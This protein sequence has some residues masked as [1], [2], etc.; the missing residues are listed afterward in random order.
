MSFT[1]EYLEEKKKK[2][3]TTAAKTGH[4]FTDNY[5]SE[6]E[7]SQ[8]LQ[9]DIAPVRTAP[10]KTTTKKDEDEERTWFKSGAFD[11]GYQFGD[12]TKTILGTVGD[13]GIGIAKGIGY[14]GEGVGDLINYADASISEKLGNQQRADYIRKRT[15]ESVTDI[16]LGGLE[17]KVDRFSVLGDK[18]DS[19]TQGI[20]QVGA[21]IATGGIAGAAGLGA[22]GTTGVT[23]GLMGASSAGSGMSEAYMSGATDEEAATYGLIKGVVDAGSEMIFGGLGKTVKA[24]GISKGLSS[25]DDVFAQKL[26]NRITNNVAKNFVEYGV[27]ASAEGVEEVLAG[28]G[29]AVGKKLTYMDD[30]ELN[31]LI[32]DENL[33]EQFVVGA[34][35]SGIAQSGLVPG[36]KGGSLKEANETG[37]DF[38][39]GMSQN[40]QKVVDKVVE[41]RIAEEEKSGKKLSNKDK[42]KIY[43]EVLEEMEKGG[44]ST[45]TIEEVLG[46]DTYKSYKDTIDSEDALA[47]E[48]EELGKKQNATLAEQ[49]RYAELHEQM[50]NKDDSKRN[51]LKSKLSEEVFG[52][53]K[54]DRLV[55]SY[56]ER[57]RKG[58]AFEADLTKYDAK[59]QETIKKAVESGILNNTRRTHEF[60][61]MV[62]KITA[63]KGVLF[64]FTNNERLK[65]SGFAVDGKTV[66]GYVTKDGVTLNIQSAKSLNSVVGHE[67]TH[68]LEGTELYTALQSAVVEY[69]KTKGDYQGR[70]DSLSAL[71]KDIKDADVDG[72]LTADLVGDYLFTDSDFINNL[73]TNNRNVF[74]KIYDE[75]KYLCKVATAG[76]KEARELEKVKRAF[77]KAYRDTSTNVELKP[78]EAQQTEEVAESN[79]KYGVIENLLSMDRVNNT[80]ANEIIRDAELSQAFTDITGVTL[81]GT[82]EQK[83]NTIRN[84]VREHQMR[85]VENEATAKAVA[86]QANAEQAMRDGGYTSYI[87]GIFAKGANVADAKEILRNPEMKAEW[88]SITGKTLPTNE[89]SAIKMIVQTER[90]PAN[91]GLPDINAKYSVSDS[92][93]QDAVNRGDTETAQMMVDEVA[94]SAMADSAIR[95]E[96]GKLL[97]VY[98]GTWEKFNVF[99]TSIS[100]GKNGTA[101][102][103]GIYTSDNSEVTSAY[104]DRQLKMYAD[105]KKPARSDRLT[106]TSS[107]L[108]KLIKDTCQR[109]AQK[110]V[111]DGDHDN[112]REAIRDTWISNYVDTYSVN[113]ETAYREVAKSIL[114]MNSSDMDVVQEVMVGMAIRD[115]ADA[116]QFYK[117]SLTPITGFDGIWTQLE[118]AD[119]KK[120]NIILAFDSSQLKQADPVTYD[121]N[122]NVIPLSERFNTEN[123]D[124]RYSMSNKGEQVAPVGNYNVYGKDMMVQ[125]ES[126]PVSKTT[127]QTKTPV[128]KTNVV[129]PISEEI[130]EDTAPVAE[131]PKRMAYEAIR[132]KPEKQPKLVRATP[133][134]QATASVLVEEPKVEKKSKAMSWIKNGILDKGMVFEDLS[135]KTGNRE[136]QA[137]WNSVRYAEGKAQR[138]MEKGNASVSSLKSIRETVEKSGKT[139]EFYEYLYHKHNADRMNLEERYEDTP[140]K[141]VFGD[142]VTSEVSQKA[143]DKLEKDHPEFKQYAKEVYGYMNHL[144]ELLVD[145]GVISN[146]TAKLWSEMYPHYVPIGRVDSNGNNIDVPL[147]TR[148]TGINAPIKK[149]TGGSS[150]IRPLFE[151]MGERTIQTYKAIAKNRFGVE[152]KNTLG[153]TIENEAV[154]LDETIDSIE[155]NEELLQK[156]KNGKNPTFTVFENGEKVTFEITDEMY[157]AMKPK[158]EA[159][160]YTNKVLNT[161]NNVRRGLLT[162][163][164]PAFMLTNPIKD[165]QD[166]V[167]NSQHPAKTYANYHKAIAELLGKNGHWYQEYMENGGE[168]N[169]YFDRETH[170][171]K[172]QSTLRKIVGFPL[173]KV[174]EANNF[175]ERVPRMAEY[176]ASRKMGRSIDVAMLDAAR[177]TTNFAAG[178]DLTKLANRN[179]FTFLNA[180]VQGAIQQVRNVREAKAN[181]LKGAMLLA[182]KIAVAGLPSILLNHL[183]W[184]DDEEYAELSDYVKQNYYIVGK[185]GDG[186]FV[187]IPKG[188]ALAVIQNAFEQMENAVTGNDEVDLATFG[189]LVINNLAPSNPLENNLLAPIA[190]AWSNKTWYGDDLV[191]TRLQDL[192]SAEQYDETTDSISK[193]LGE[194]TPFS[195]YKINYVL[196]Q[197]SGAVGDMLLPRLTLEAERG[198]NSWIAPISDKFTTDSVM[199]NQN[200]SDF[201]DLKDELAVNANGSKA[202]DE[203]VLKYK[204]I[205][206]VNAEMGKLYGEKREIQNSDLPDAEK[207]EAVREIQKEIDALAETALDSYEDVEVGDGKDTYYAR[208]ADRQYRWNQKDTDPEG[209]WVKLTDEQI[210]KQEKVTSKLGITPD[211]YWSNAKEEYDFAYEKPEKYAVAKSVGGYEA[212][213]GYSS[214]LYDIKADKDENGKSISGSR[215]EKVLDYI[216]NLDADYGTRLILFKSEYP[217]YDDANYDIIDYLNGRDDISYDEMVSILKELGFDVS[218]DGTISWD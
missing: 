4:S 32:Q 170:T 58:Q 156:G 144:R 79:D 179:G 86:E 2:K 202:T 13:A 55:E 116:M 201:Y 131:T 133:E 207:Y 162:E 111:D 109:E 8:A 28:I 106:I 64:D 69:A 31:A 24:L 60:V 215:K 161:A 135:L 17:K 57:A 10:V 26:A 22:V 37:R 53:V 45:D 34:V 216:N 148:R 130:V 208:V 121:D 90:N 98:H 117:N 46:G 6:R 212:Y 183:L 203:D 167:I 187:R 39:S 59:Q 48:Y 19:V 214:E 35:T 47:K 175:I 189:E 206:S 190:Q 124:I 180:S 40:E 96:D 191:P 218:S 188:R 198:N 172:E 108:A 158:S 23:M 150:D 204:Y 29:S 151:V 36:M 95:G 20:G 33:M 166:V 105:I 16:I 199:K 163:Y 41:D 126:A 152:L 165:T 42:N 68:V 200:V 38:I 93:Y 67:I 113:I 77:E 209:E 181:G 174:S 50:K 100:G 88:E 192:P 84:T 123:Q 125:K 66:N 176:I 97:P 80:F 83:R 78:T 155:A 210:E 92:D 196:D 85:S 7:K 213:K 186:K 205:N 1:D 137:R 73:H 184:D 25:L 63:D 70:Y 194:R 102:G 122:G 54:G 99:D 89:K 15:Q 115:Y 185:Y 12:I 139:K 173:D 14:L 76:S 61:D 149:A 65:E 114:D 160:A 18:A 82:T 72:E 107:K 30:K 49:T 211:Q 94:E 178:G 134:E 177:V 91:I 132:P 56:N 127:A 129:P 168:Q 141:P 140:N 197:Y 193:W 43:D 51:Q 145:N 128:S 171:F 11:D 118:D 101:E 27:K 146:E 142:S 104:G 52:M 147:D 154:G 143:A 81:E 195:P 138:L 112:L 87:R 74:Q 182:S 9:E 5:L 159:M 3:K 153:T 110:F 119:G 103:F 75:I 136:L 62:A 44:I 164:N 21:I 217:S 71:Y 157:D 169:T 120:S